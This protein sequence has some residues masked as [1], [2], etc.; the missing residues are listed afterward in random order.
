MKGEGVKAKIALL[1]PV[2]KSLELKLT[3]NMSP[4]RDHNKA[5]LRVKTKILKSTFLSQ[6]ASSLHISRHPDLMLQSV[7]M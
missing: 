4:E 1:K 6:K 3:K 7:K 5:H 2:I